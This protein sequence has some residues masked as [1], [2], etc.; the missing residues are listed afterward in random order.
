VFALVASTA[1]G[2]II[3]SGSGDDTPP[4]DTGLITANWSF[5]ELAT[6][7]I[8][9]CPSGF[10]T[11]AFYAYP[12]DAANARLGEPFID[13]YQCGA[14]TGTSDYPLGRYEV[15][16]EIT[17]GTNTGLYA[18]TLPAIVDI[19]PDDATFTTTVIDDGGFFLFD[20]ELRGE[21]SGTPLTCTQAGAT[22]GVDITATLSGTAEATT[23]VF[24]CEQGTAY[25]GGLIAGTYVV[26][27][28]ALNSA[29]QAV[30]VAPE[31]VNKAIQAPNKVT[32]LGLI[33]IPITG[34]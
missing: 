22:G 3:E 25:T 30:G 17:N 20:W 4:I 9:P 26:S 16:L 19:R 1:T 21:T 6:N 13:L 5:K 18:Q 23:D 28:A 14:G 8:L 24:P 34:Q 32:D 15:Y 12:V 27:V 11:A 31:L 10:N 7:A 33:M 2:C 29:D